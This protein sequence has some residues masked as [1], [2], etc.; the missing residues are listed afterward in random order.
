[1]LHIA[2]LNNKPKLN[3][4]FFFYKLFFFYTIS[5]KIT[6]ASHSLDSLVYVYIVLYVSRVYSC[7]P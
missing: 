6:K 5:S 7:V 2:K 1:M 4:N 3:G